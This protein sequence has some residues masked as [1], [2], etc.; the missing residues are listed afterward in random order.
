MKPFDAYKAV[1]VHDLIAVL[2]YA[3]IVPFL[4]CHPVSVVADAND[5]RGVHL[6]AKAW[7]SQLQLISRPTL[8][9]LEISK[10]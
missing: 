10:S 9:K 7:I 5:E 1:V 2:V 8:E 4:S 6:H 3:K